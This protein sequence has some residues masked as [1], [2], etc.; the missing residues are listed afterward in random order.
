MIVDPD[1]PDHWKTRMLVDAL[2]GDEAAPVYLLRLWGHCQN[3]KTAS[4]DSLP[5]AAL[6]ALCRF[7]GHANKLESSLA[8]SGF[9]RRDDQVLTVIGWENYNASLIANWTNGKAGGRPRGKKAGTPDAP[10]KPMGSP[11]VT[12]GEPI[13]VDERRRERERALAPEGSGFSEI[14]PTGVANDFGALTKRINSLHPSWAKRPALSHMEQRDLVANAKPFF[15]LEEADW[16]LLKMFFRVVIPEDW[17]KFWRPD[18]R[19]KF[20]QDINDVLGHA[21]RWRDE[22]ARRKVKTGLEAI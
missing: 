14:M 21:D 9:I 16:E 6:K 2:G 13:R 18:S 11:S 15:A 8:S 4:F 22:C 17:G 3:R 12:H 1:F 19:G 10:K 5:S 7:P 20:I